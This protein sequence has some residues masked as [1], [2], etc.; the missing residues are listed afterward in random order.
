MSVSVLA[1]HLSCMTVLQ[2]PSLTTHVTVPAP[3]TLST[4]STSLESYLDQVLRSPAR[5]LT[6]TQ[7]HFAARRF[8]NLLCGHEV[9]VLLAGDRTPGSRLPNSLWAELDRL[10]AFS[11]SPA[12]R[13]VARTVLGLLQEHEQVLVDDQLTPDPVA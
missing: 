11:V 7:M 10:T 4:R 8:R 9:D 2:F 6:D 1:A 3:R 12:T 5:T 13:L